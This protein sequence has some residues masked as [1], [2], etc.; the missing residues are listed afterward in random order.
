MGEYVLAVHAGA[1]DA[2][3][4]DAAASA[5]IRD[6]LRNALVAGRHVLEAAGSAMDAVEHAVCALEAC[7]L[8]NA[9]RGSVVNSEGAVE[10]DASI[11]CGRALAAGGVA[12]ATRIVH[13][14]SAARAVMMHT[15]HVLLVGAA[16]D[17]FAERVNLAV[18]DPSYFITEA[19]LRQLERAR[20]G[21][22]VDLDRG[23]VGAVALDRGGH[24]AAATSTGGTTNKLPGRVGDS[25][26]IGAGT[27]AADG[28]CAV[29]ATGNGELILRVAM[30]HEI[31]AR[32]RLN[33]ETVADAAGAALALVGSRG[34]GAGCIAIDAAGRIAMPF[35][36]P[37]M[38][39]G[40]IRGREPA[41]TAIGPEELA[42]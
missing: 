8:F 20:R 18:A 21:I 29:S 9:G 2:V 6:G 24:L 4:G 25:P 3:P 19:R 42:E 35:N 40:I 23:T 12:G 5:R 33:G 32:M 37:V 39:R 22:A 31:D 16:A 34:G 15:P 28:R 17:G 30:A 27:W 41:L 1:G 7:E 36:T 26:I 11:M 38:L 13:P 10:M 14:V